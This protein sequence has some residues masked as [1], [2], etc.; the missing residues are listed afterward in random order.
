MK[1][2]VKMS[3]VA[4]VAVAGLT[5]ANAKPLEEAIK[6]VDVSGT[7]VYRYD[8]R[9]R[10]TTATQAGQNSTVT[11]NYKIGVNLKSK[12]NDDVTYQDKKVGYIKSVKNVE[13]VLF[14]DVV[15]TDQ[16]VLNMME[17]QKQPQLSVGYSKVNGRSK[18]SKIKGVKSNEQK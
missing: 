9:N 2:I 10:D 17:N 5:A 6:N 15:I 16:D 18:T 13:G 12:V 11:N 4:A 1:K 7:V 14:Y 8:D 3:L